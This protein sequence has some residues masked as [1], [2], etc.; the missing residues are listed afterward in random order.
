MK[1][2]AVSPTTTPEFIEWWGRRINDNIPGPSQGDSQATG[3]YLRVVP[4]K[5][6]IIR[7]DFE[8]INSELE[9]KI[10]QMEEEKMNLR[11]DIYV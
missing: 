2:L 7:Q 9:K 1:R 5:L 10:K 4:S 8:R 6:E 11:L 3:K